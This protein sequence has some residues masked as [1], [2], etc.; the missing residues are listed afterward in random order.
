MDWIL[1]YKSAK[2]FHVLQAMCHSYIM[3][4]LQKKMYVLN[5]CT[6]LGMQSN[7]VIP[8]RTA[9]A[10]VKIWWHLCIGLVYPLY[11]KNMVYGQL[12]Y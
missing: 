5:C 12:K 7:C 6:I 3:A 9:K 10:L 2:V 1:W 8:K 4:I 11:D